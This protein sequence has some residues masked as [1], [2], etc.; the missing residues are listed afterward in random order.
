MTPSTSA[1]RQSGHNATS[2][3]LEP[4][5]D[6]IRELF[7]ELSSTESETP[8]CTPSLSTLP[9]ELVHQIIESTVPHTF[10]STTY[11]QRSGTLRSV[12]LV[13]KLFYSIAQPL[14]LEMVWINIYSARY[15]M[16]EQAKRALARTLI[17]LDANNFVPQYL[18]PGAN[19]RSLT[20][21]FTMLVPVPLDPISNCRNLADLQLAGSAFFLKR[22]NSFPSI[23]TLSITFQAAH[24]VHQL[25]NA[26]A[27]PSL[28]ALGLKGS[29]D[30]SVQSPGGVPD[31]ASLLPQLDMLVAPY[32]FYTARGID[33]HPNLASKTLVDIHLNHL[34]RNPANLQTLH[35]IDYAPKSSRYI[36]RFIHY[37]RLKDFVFKTAVFGRSV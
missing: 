4:L 10:H 1:T 22:S 33:H 18:I 16:L 25:V 15:V 6:S 37:K 14:L 7:L 5:T 26:E 28:T 24:A 21:V 31:F 32:S 35:H 8:R 34:G 13:S 9:P 12:S 11:K 20:L 27:L 19:I 36:D 30:P 17:I 29:Y 23:R 3:S 2:L